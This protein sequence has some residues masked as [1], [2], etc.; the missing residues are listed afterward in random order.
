MGI[1]KTSILIITRNRGRVLRDALSAVQPQ[2]PVAE[3][4]VIVVDS[5]VHNDTQT[6]IQG[7]SWVKYVHI[8]LPLGTRPQS[9]S[10]GAEQAEGDVVILIDD[11]SIVMPGWLPALQDGY[12]DLSVGA[13]GGR[14]LPRE[15]VEMPAKRE[16]EPIGAVCESGRIISNLSHDSGQCVEVDVL[17]GCNMSVRRDLLEKMGY[18]DKRFRGQNCRVE[19]DICLWVK[20][21]GFKV[22]FEPKAVVRHLAE[23]RPDVPRSEKNIRS[24]FY[25]WRNTVWLYLKHFEWTPK[26]IIHIGL[27]T[28]V[29]TCLRRVLGGSFKTPRL[30]QESVRYFPAAV[31]GI[32]GGIWGVAMS[33]LYTAWDCCFRKDKPR[34]PRLSFH[35]KTGKVMLKGG[36]N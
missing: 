4:E 5:D 20:R 26:L 6:L 9:Y 13:V 22:I 14:I 3:C 2:L 21:M 28:P 31:A 10:R 36:G 19:D 34:F 33:F 18:F 7:L 17:R 32:W 15:G 27:L 1:L 23:E 30:N 29:K 35:G 25:V 8:K 16:D 24:E 11:D 12:E